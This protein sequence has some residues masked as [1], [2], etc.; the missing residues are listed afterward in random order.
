MGLLVS[1]TEK[2]FPE[3]EM[4]SMLRAMRTL[5]ATELTALLDRAGLSQAGFARLAG[6]TARQVNN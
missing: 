6:V 4:V 2:S 1:Q 5:L 3:I